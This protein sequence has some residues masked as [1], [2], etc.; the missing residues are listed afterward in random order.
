VID[1]SNGPSRLSAPRRP[2]QALPPDPRPPPAWTQAPRWIAGA[3]IVLAAAAT[4]VL[5]LPGHYSYDS[6][7]Q[8]AEGRTGSYAGQHPPVMSWLLGLAD[9]VRPGGA[10]FVVFDVLLVDGAL[11]ALVMLGRPGSW[12]AVVLAGLAA[13][14]PQLLIYPAIVWKDVLFAGAGCAG[15]AALAW[16]AASRRS[17]VRSGLMAASLVLLTLAALARQNGAV[18]WPFGAAAAGWIAA[19]SGS[20]GAVRRGFVHGL[21]FIAA[22]AALTLGATAALD[23]RLDVANP[24]GEAWRNL[25]AYDLIAAAARDPHLEMAVFDA[26]APRLAKLV[27]T[28]GVRA[29]SPMRVDTV[30]PVV[31]RMDASGA[32]AAL[33]AA[34]WRELILRHPLLYLQVRAQ[35]F[36]WVFVPLRPSQCLLVETGVDGPAGALAVSGLAERDTDRDDA[37]EAYALKFAGTPAYSHAAYAAAGLVLLGLVLRR[38]RPEDIAVAAMLAS[39]FAFAASFALISIACD[40]RYLYFLDL[41]VIAAALYAAAS[42]GKAGRG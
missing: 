2:R 25:E 7:V 12:L 42:F 24:L 32:G 1:G 3:I 37:I 34:Q 35:A 26:R 4:L 36:E 19:G 30:E 13:L 29:Y 10:L 6:V 18:V 21:A 8:L 41:S 15:F 11:L 31:E 9:R 17:T 38:R 20:G 33:I 16:A 27:R 23:T 39:A 14:L 22:G 5:N 28:D 40:Y